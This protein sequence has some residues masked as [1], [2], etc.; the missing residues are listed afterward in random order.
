M[1]QDTRTAEEKIEQLYFHGGDKDESISKY[2]ARQKTIAA[3][4]EA[5]GIHY[6]WMG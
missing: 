6:D 1:K 3:T 5:L 4:L 2:I